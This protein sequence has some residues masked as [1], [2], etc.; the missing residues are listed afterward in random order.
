[1]KEVIKLL[2]KNV[3][4]KKLDPF[5]G[6]NSLLDFLVDLFDIRHFQKNW[7]EYMAKRKEE[8][9]TLFQICII[10]MEKVESALNAGTWIDFFGGIYEELYQSKYK[11]SETGQF[12]TPPALCDLLATLTTIRNEHRETV[13]DNAC[14]SGRTL[15]SDFASDKYNVKNYYTADDIDIVSVKMCALNMM[16]HGM[17]GRVMQHDTLTNPILFDFG[18]E[19]NEVRYP[20]PTP[21]YSLR[22]ISFTKEDLDR[23]NTKVR[24]RYGDNV[25]VEQYSGYEVVRPNKDV[26]PQFKPMYD[27]P[28]IGNENPNDYTQLNLFGNGW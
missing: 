17:R 13:N 4:E 6:L 19:I 23:Q 9:P 28:P 27:T 14:G 21:F 2:E 7:L 12:F 8:E 26:K 18:Y 24:E 22:Q 20:F 16:M 25:K 3:A 5:L 10:W 1:M 15:L 11:A